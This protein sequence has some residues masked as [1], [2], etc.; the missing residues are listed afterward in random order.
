MPPPPPSGSAA[1]AGYWAALAVAGT[2]LLGGLA[3]PLAGGLVM[4]VFL[5]VALGIRRQ[6]AWSAIAGV[7]FVLAP[8]PFAAIHVSSA[9]TVGFIGAAV[10]EVALS[11]FLAQAA[12]EL[13]HDP[14]N[15]RPLPWVIFAVASV[16][17][18]MVFEPFAINGGSMQKTILVED[19]ILVETASWRLGRT[20]ELGQL[21][22]VQYPLD[23][24]QR[25]IKRVVA[26]PG[27]RV[28][29]RDKRLYRNGEPVEEPYAIHSSPAIEVFRDNFP[30]PATIQLASAAEDMLRYHVSNGDVLLPDGKYFVLGDNRDDSLDSRYWGFITAKDVVG[31][32]LL[33]YGSYDPATRPAIGNTVRNLRWNRLGKFLR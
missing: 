29:F 7:C 1:R 16:L 22:V 30:A 28:H 10:V 18:W 12:I 31:S 26:G 4:L 5:C 15:R 3:N 11:F 8:V 2:G 14:A 9:Q 23:H 24:K 17:F 21:V 13:W 19:Q 27:D 25:F 6:H 20:P 32:P 33:V